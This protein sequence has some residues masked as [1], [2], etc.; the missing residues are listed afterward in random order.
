MTCS[1][2]RR[3]APGSAPPE[4]ATAKRSSSRLKAD[5]DGFALSA[6]RFDHHHA[7]AIMTPPSTSAPK[8]N[9]VKKT[10]WAS[11]TPLSSDESTATTGN[12]MT[13]RIVA[14]GDASATWI[15]RLVEATSFRDSARAS[16]AGPMAD[17]E[18]LAT[19]QHA[20]T[21]RHAT[22][23]S[24]VTSAMASWMFR[25][26]SNSSPTREHASVAECSAN[27]RQADTG[28]KPAFSRVAN[29]AIVSA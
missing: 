10:V 13:N 14:K 20:P 17:P 27:S 3:A 11:P 24:A 21:L 19:L 2:V 5:S 25:P 15:S 26:W 18:R 29:R 6:R 1:T 9:G 7:T 8:P 28:A 16:S 22:D 12:T 23:S 4:Q